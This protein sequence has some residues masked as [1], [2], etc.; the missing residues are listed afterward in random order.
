[1]LIG[2]RNVI[3]NDVDCTGHFT[4]HRNITDQQLT[5]TIS[6]SIGLLTALTRLCVRHF[7]VL[8]ADSRSHCKQKHFRYLHNKQ[9]SGALTSYIGRLTALNELCVV[10]LNDSFHLSWIAQDIGIESI[11]WH[12]SKTNWAIDGASTIVRCRVSF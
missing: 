12:N 1:M 3:L 10:G 11:Q 9:L 7:V 5:G 6:S 8:I 4:G 2:K